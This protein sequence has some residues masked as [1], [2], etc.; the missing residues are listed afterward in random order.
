MDLSLMIMM[1]M[2]KTLLM[3][4]NLNWTK[5]IKNLKRF[6]TF[7]TSLPNLRPR[8]DSRKGVDSRYPPDSNFSRAAE[9]H[10][11]NDTTKWNLQEIKSNFNSKMLNFNLP[12]NMFKKFDKITIRRIP[13]FAFRTTDPKPI[14]FS[15][16]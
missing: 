1:K 12:F 5:R 6:A 11:N 13:P 2:V 8:V 9:R 7:F 3:N 14:F 4:C 15:C 16:R 10:K